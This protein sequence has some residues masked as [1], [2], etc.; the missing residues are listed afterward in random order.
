M[1]DQAVEAPP[2][3][4]SAPLADVPVGARFTTRGRTVTEADV[5]GFAGLTGDVHP[6]H[7]DAVYAAATPFGQRIAHGLLVV[8]MAVG[9]VP[10][11]PRRVLALRR[12][13]DVV[14]KRP[15]HLGDTIH[16]EGRV[17]DVRPMTD[18][19]GLVSCAWT[20]HTHE[21]GLVTRVAVDLLWA[22]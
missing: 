12:I 17:T 3:V 9:L 5:V 8:S 14:L 13:S 19:A 2:V 4:W 22:T 16:V 6:V 21:S 1:T 10:L 15:V 7:T 11:D 18:E 20:I